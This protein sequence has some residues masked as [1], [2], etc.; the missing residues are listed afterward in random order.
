MPGLWIIPAGAFAGGVVGYLAWRLFVSD[1]GAGDGASDLTLSAPAPRGSAPAAGGLPRDG[2]TPD[3]P[4][5]VA[6]AAT[7]SSSGASAAGPKSGARRSAAVGPASLQLPEPPPLP[8]RVDPADVA[9]SHTARAVHHE[10]EGEIPQARDHF[11]KALSLYESAGDVHG[12]LHTC[13]LLASLHVSARDVAGAETYWR[14]ALSLATARG[15]RTREISLLGRLGLAAAGDGRWDD[16]RE[17]LGEAL[18]MEEAAWGIP[19]TDQP[20][21][22]PGHHGASRSLP[23]TALAFLERA[24]GLAPE[25]SEFARYCAGVLERVR[26]RV[27]PGLAGSTGSG[28]GNG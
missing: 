11:L 10:A 9:R 13:D 17:L 22:P 8:A 6:S 5:S 1:P 15:L 18:K 7:P 26:I 4:S 19:V 20:D 2:G 16:A 23:D 21:G 3:A 12:V 24:A 25:G 28:N 14:Y 27:S